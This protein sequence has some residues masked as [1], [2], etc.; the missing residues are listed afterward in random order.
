MHPH[1]ISK[2]RIKEAMRADRLVAGSRG[3]V[4]CP[5]TGVGLRTGSLGVGALRLASVHLG[6][7]TD[8]LPLLRVSKHSARA[9]AIWTAVCTLIF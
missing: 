4:V 6:I 1:L 9:C 3:R 8:P 5:A 2:A 7:L